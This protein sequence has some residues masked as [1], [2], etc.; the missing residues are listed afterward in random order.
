MVGAVRAVCRIQAAV[1]RDR[2]LLTCLTLRHQRARWRAHPHS[3]FVFLL[4]VLLRF[5]Y[6]RAVLRDSVIVERQSEQSRPVRVGECPRRRGVAEARALE[7]GVERRERPESREERTDFE[8][9]DAVEPRVNGTRQQIERV[10]SV[11]QT[12][13][14]LRPV[15]QALGIREAPG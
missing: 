12:R 5:A 3:R 15:E 4:A 2:N 8:S 11:A 6:C 10:L 14:N 13:R 9:A 1:Y 7:D